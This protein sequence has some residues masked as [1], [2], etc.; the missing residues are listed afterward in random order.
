MK[1]TEEQMTRYTNN[2]V[3]KFIQTKKIAHD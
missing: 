1:K 2:T 3:K